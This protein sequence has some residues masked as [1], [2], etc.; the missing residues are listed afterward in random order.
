MPQGSINTSSEVTNRPD[1]GAARKP[2]NSASMNTSP[3]IK[4]P[5]S[6]VGCKLDPA[7][8]QDIANGL[9]EGRTINDLA[10]SY[11][12]SP[13]TVGVLRNRHFDSIPQP[14]QR[15]ATKLGGVAE[16]AADRMLQMIEDGS[17]SD[18][19]LP[20]M[21]G[22]SIEKAMLLSGA[23]PT[24]RVEHISVKSDSIGEILDRL[25]SANTVPVASKGDGTDA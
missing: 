7:M 24:T 16:A 5:D 10:N 3:I 1:I 22:V 21:A 11:G 6:G 4:Q 17:V 14:K 15:L 18:R 2:T 12:V 8:Y 13:S 9:V 20:V 25:P 23:V 19:A